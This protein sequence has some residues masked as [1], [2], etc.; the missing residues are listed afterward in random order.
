[1]YGLGHFALQ[2]KL[3]QHY[4]SLYANKNKIKIEKIKIPEKYCNLQK[5][6]EN[7][8]PTLRKTPSFWS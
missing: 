3:T 5:I 7:N 6:K 2:Q 8:P 1:M 4:K